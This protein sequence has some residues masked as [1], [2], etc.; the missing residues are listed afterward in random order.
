[1]HTT[2]VTT[3]PPGDVREVVRLIA[4]DGSGH[5]TGALLPVTGPGGRS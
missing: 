1:M 4:P 5:R 3:I 2:P